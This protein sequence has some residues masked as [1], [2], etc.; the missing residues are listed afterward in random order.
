MSSPDEPVDRTGTSALDER[1]ASAS[2]LAAAAVVGVAVLAVALATWRPWTVLVGSLGGICSAGAIRW[3]D[4]DRP[5]VVA[6][7]TV[8]GLVA[9]CLVTLAPLVSGDAAWVALA[10]SLA[11]FGAAGSVLSAVG[12]GKV[13]DGVGMLSYGILAFWLVTIAASLVPVYDDLFRVT[14]G[15][16][17]PGNAG[18]DVFG[19]AVLVT[20]ATGT[21]WAALRALPIV[22]LAPKAERD[23]LRD[24]LDRADRALKRATLVGF[25]GMGAGI[26]FAV[27]LATISLPRVVLAAISL[28]VGNPVLRAP[29]FAVSVVAGSVALGAKVVE[30]TGGTILA[31]ARRG[32]AVGAGVLFAIAV[33]VFH[34]VVVAVVSS[35][36][37]W[38]SAFEWHP[39]LVVMLLVAFGILIHA[40][41]MLGLPALV[42]I[43]LAP[44]RAAG[45]AFAAAGLVA[46]A[47]AV[48]TWVHPLVVLGLVVAGVVAWDLGEFGVGVGEEVGRRVDTTRIET[49]HAAGSVGVGAVAL[50]VAGGAW[51]L[52]QVLNSSGRIALIALGAAVFGAFLLVAALRG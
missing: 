43:R 9:G 17:V 42:G 11:S 47:V 22:E 12:D 49:V 31:R 52:V 37:G 40:L 1:P 39:L 23:D 20:L 15:V 48:A 8:L 50:L 25:L 28:S 29:L 45:R 36:E 6:G 7:G 35:L 41:V 5:R 32:S 13:L 14:L 34:P 38:E 44:E 46:G 33:A 18:P 10:V 21:V 19:F 2:T 24:A 27:L 16:F 51:G 30:R 4:D 26:A 3:L